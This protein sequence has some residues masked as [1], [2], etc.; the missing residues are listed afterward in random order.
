MIKEI[1]LAA[2]MNCTP[3]TEECL[4][5]A[6]LQMNTIEALEEVLRLYPGN[7]QCRDALNRFASPRDLQRTRA[8]PV[9]HGPY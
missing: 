6:A 1:L 2:M 7:R 4:C 8:Q 5:N 9:T 3:A